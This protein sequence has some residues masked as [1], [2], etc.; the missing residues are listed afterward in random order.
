MSHRELASQFAD[1]IL[2]RLSWPE[3]QARYSTYA[4]FSFFIALQLT[5][6]QIRKNAPKIIQV[7]EMGA[8]P[9]TAPL[10]SAAARLG[11]DGLPLLLKGIQSKDSEIYWPA[12]DGA[13][14][15]DR[16]IAP[17]L[18]PVI[19]ALFSESKIGS[20]PIKLVI[21][22]AG[23]EG[24]QAAEDAISRMPEANRARMTQA[25]NHHYNAKGEFDCGN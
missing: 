3:P 4:S 16:S 10:Y 24:R 13:C 9:N 19:N 2:T 22:L 20:Y 23:L 6:E 1:Q 7:L 15:A 21:A 12:I 18:T 5:D 17:S 14:R 11:K 25:L 8:T